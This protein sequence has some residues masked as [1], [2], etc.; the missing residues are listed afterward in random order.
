M[1]K[2][3]LNTWL[4]ATFFFLMLFGIIMVYSS[5]AFYAQHYF[6]DHLYFLKRHLLWL[7]LGL[8]AMA[9]AYSLPYKKLQGYTWFVLFAAGMIL[10]YAAFIERSRWVQF[11]PIHFQAVDVAKFGIILFFADSL[12]RKEKFLADYSEGLFPHLVYLALF[13]GMVLYQ[14]DF[15]S[16][17]ML[18]LL[19]L[20]MLFA[21]PVKIFHLV[22]TGL[23]FVP[24]LIMTIFLSPYKLKRVLAYLN[25]KEDIQGMG[26]QVYQSLVSFGHG[27]ITGVGFAGSTQK[28]FFLPEAHTDFIFAI[29]GE[30]WGLIGTLLLACLFGVIL[31]QGIKITLHTTDRF[32]AFLTVGVTAHFIYY[33]VINMMVTLHLLPA[34]G[35]PLPFVSYG[36]TALLFSCVYAGMLLR[37]SNETYGRGGAAKGR[38]GRKG[39][40][41]AQI[42][43]MHYIPLSSV[44]KRRRR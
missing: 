23:A 35:L 6:N 42:Q 17:F 25:P 3:Y 15:S 37:M 9:I 29:I 28:M 32:F 26:Y 39:G 13:A 41:K 22:L 14:P 34:T 7:F 4:V 5:S 31:V 16:A 44:K 2:R 36:G 43:T 27:G 24:P 19:G 18:I 10:F 1:N 33:A 38:A 11:G 40:R 21:A 20:T 8:I 12:S 30:E